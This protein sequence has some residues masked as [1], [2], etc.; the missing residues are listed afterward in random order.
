M[1]LRYCSRKHAATHRRCPKEDCTWAEARDQKEKTRHVWYTHKPWAE[2]T[3]Y[4]PMG[5]QCDECTAVFTRK[6]GVS[7][8]KKEVHGA[9]KRARKLGG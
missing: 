5:A 9:I 6:D 7:R 3:K 1:L 2:K 8:H 4:P